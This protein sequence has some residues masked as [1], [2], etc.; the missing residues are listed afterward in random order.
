MAGDFPFLVVD[1]FLFRLAIFV[2]ALL[3][4]GRLSRFKP[5]ERAIK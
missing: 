3:W 1:G 5:A 4:D 2:A